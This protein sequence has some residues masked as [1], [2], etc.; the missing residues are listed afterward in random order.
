MPTRFR[1]HPGIGIAR[2]GNSPAS[3]YIAPETTGALPID[4]DAGGNPIVKDGVEQPVSKFKDGQ[5][6]IRRQAAR[7][8]VFAYDDASPHGRE[9]RIGDTLDIIDRHSGQHRRVRIDDI[10]WTVHLANKKA[11]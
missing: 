11:S 7:F 9:A 5:G 4:C 8:R 2:V 1:I 3:F 10:H 6:R